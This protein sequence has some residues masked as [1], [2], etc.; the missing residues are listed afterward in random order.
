[1]D[2]YRRTATVQIGETLIKSGV[3]DGNITGLSVAFSVERTTK[4]T[5]NKAEVKIRNLSPDTRQKIGE[6]RDVFVSV[7]AGYND[8]EH[9]IFAGNGEA[10]TIRDANTIVTVV[11][12][13]DGQKATQTGRVSL[14][15]GKNAKVGDVILETGKKLLDQMG[16]SNAATGNLERLKNVSLEKVTNVFSNGVVVHGNTSA[17]F[18]K[19]LESAGYEYS[20]QNGILQILEKDRARTKVPRVKLTYSTGLLSSPERS[21]DGIVKARALMIPYIDPGELVEFEPDNTGS[22][23]EGIF[24]IERVNFTGDMSTAEWYADIE[25]REL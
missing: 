7:A 2:L 19:L 13:G 25:A 17:E 23:V 5:P 12:S 15:Y 18:S 11:T 16:L 14:S 6:L 1:M 9:L 10:D 3:K 20:I 8:E 21:S 22:N 24:R 4:R